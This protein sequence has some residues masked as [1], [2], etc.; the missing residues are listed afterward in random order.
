[1]NVMWYVGKFDEATWCLFADLGIGSSYL[2][3][4]C[5]GMVAAEQSL[6]YKRELF[7]GDTL[8]IHSTLLEVRRSSLKFEHIMWKNGEDAEVAT[9]TITGVHIDAIARRACP[10]PTEI[11]KALEAI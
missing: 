11:L 4:A 10:F 3:E 5:R 9:S 6:A 1:M 8:A 7:A 2:R